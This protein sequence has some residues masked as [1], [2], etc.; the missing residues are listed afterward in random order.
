MIK[1]RSA[2]TLTELIVAIAVLAILAGLLFPVLGKIRERSH[3]TTCAANLKQIGLALQNYAHD[4]QG[5]YPPIH[6]LNDNSNCSLW[7]DRVFP[8]IKK[9]E[10]FWCPANPQGEYEPG[11]GPSAN[12]GLQ[13]EIRYD[14]SYDLTATSGSVEIINSSSSVT[15]NITYPDAPLRQ[16]RIRRPSDVILLLDGTGRF[17]NPGYQEPP[18]SGV[19]GLLQRG[20]TPRHYRGCNVGFADGRVKWLSLQALTDVHLWRIAN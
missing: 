1:R 13:D 20:V 8:Y 19:E 6:P 16:L 5:G 15:H 17:V 18:F 14:G 3:A 2:F 4:H 9:S 11:C 7:A 10:I 12:A